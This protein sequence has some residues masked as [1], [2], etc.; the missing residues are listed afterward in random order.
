MSR[1]LD[2]YFSGIRKTSTKLDIYKEALK[3]ALEVSMSYV[4][5]RGIKNNAN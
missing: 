5:S 4:A 3:K 1:S 2:V